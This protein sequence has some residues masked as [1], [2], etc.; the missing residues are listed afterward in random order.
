MRARNIKPGFFKNEHLAECDPLVRLLFVGLWCMS[1]KEGIVEYRP[2]K[3]RAEIFPYENG[4]CNIEKF[5]DQL[6]ELK[7]ITFLSH[8]ETGHIIILINKFLKHQKPHKNE[9]SCGINNLQDYQEITGNYEKLSSPLLNDVCCLMNDERGISELP[10]SEEPETE[11]PYQDI[12][13]LWNND[14]HKKFN[15]PF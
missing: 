11:I 7:L 15:L 8:K 3:I 13:D 6:R 5:L 1:F 12:F 14:I 10:D 2:R 4:S 9:K